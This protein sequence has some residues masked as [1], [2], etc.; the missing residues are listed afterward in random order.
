MGSRILFSA[1]VALALVVG[2]RTVYR[3]GPHEVFGLKFGSKMH[4]TDFTVY[5]EAGRA[6]LGGQNIYEVE[7]PR[8][9]VYQYL[10]VFSVV[11]V[12]LAMVSVFWASLGWYVLSLAMVVHA[13]WLSVRVVRRFWP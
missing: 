5:Y 13:V 2:V 12:P 4:R 9:W 7:N 11:M 3:S 1:A 8:G 6:V 10:P